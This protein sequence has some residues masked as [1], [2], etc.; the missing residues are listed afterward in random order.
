MI[1]YL[2]IRNKNRVKIGIVDAF[3]SIIWN[4]VFYG[5]GTFEIYAPFDSNNAE[6]LQI[7][8]YVSRHGRRDIGII[9]NVNIN[10]EAGGAL[11]I[12]AS[13][14]F[15]KSILDRR[16]IYSLNGNVIT[17][18]VFRGNVEA[19][20]RSL[21]NQSIINASDSA[22]NVS[23]IELGASA[24]LGAKLVN[25]QQTSF[26]NLLEI[27]D[28]M[29]HEY[30]YGSYMTLNESTL[31]LQYIVFAGE[32]RTKGT[33]NPLIFSQEYDN[34]LSNDYTEYNTNE[35]NVALCGGAGE[36]VER[37][38]ILL[39]DDGKSG[40]DRRELFVDGS[41]NSET[42]ENEQGQSETYPVG[43]YLAMLKTTAR[44]ELLQYKAAQEVN[45]ELDVTTSGLEFESDYNVGDLITIIDNVLNLE[46]KSRI[47]EV[48]EVQ[49]GGGYSVNIKVENSS[50]IAAEVLTTEE[51]ARDV[52]L[53]TERGE[54]IIT[55]W[56]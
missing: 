28:D 52:V 5:V 34:L 4:V 6:L 23:F 16:L 14:R 37:K 3:A 50:T 26:G 39:N 18:V 25:E 15:A 9:E 2:V 41:S 35:K 24:G 27:T 53:L 55:R 20:A 40:I 43:E 33:S 30:N 19:A 22:R 7:G 1:D 49:D 8:N 36:G 17:P 46:I 11:M 45:A 31:K 51:T 47:I 21:V 13:G 54:K 56:I 29:L 10:Y 32:D 42:Y 44:Q 48:N 38:Y 12:T